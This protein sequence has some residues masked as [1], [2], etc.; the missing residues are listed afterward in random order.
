MSVILSPAIWYSAHTPDL[1]VFS[2]HANELDSNI[3]FGLLSAFVLETRIL[4]SR[5]LIV[6]DK[7]RRMK[8]VQ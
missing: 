5:R 7:K 1:Q 4:Y 6:S 2:H 8:G 3:R